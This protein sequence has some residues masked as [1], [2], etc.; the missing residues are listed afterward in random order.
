MVAA[1]NPTDIFHITAIANLASI[2]ASN[3]LLCKRALDQQKKAYQSIAYENLQDRRAQRIVRKGE[4]L[5]DFVP[6][7]FAPRSPMLN[8][9]H[10]GNV[11]GFKGTQADIAHLVSDAQ[12]AATSKLDFVF[13]DYHA[14]VA[15]S[16]FYDQLSDLDKIDWELF[17]ET[18]RIG[19]FCQYWFSTATKQRYF[20]RSETRQAEFLVHGMFPLTLIREIGVADGKIASK[21]VAGLEA[22]GWQVP[23]TAR[24]E[25]YY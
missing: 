14:V 25:W 16:K 18:P 22:I 2:A 3:A 20:K 24:P 10:H 17:F 21:L 23:V 12:A 4:N 13:S 8:A 1:P 5:H 19:G 6:F 9:I 11:R 7:M 15:Y